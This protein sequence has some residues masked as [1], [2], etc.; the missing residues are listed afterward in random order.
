MGVFVLFAI[1]L[2]RADALLRPVP[3]V[4]FSVRLSALPV[5]PV[6]PVLPELH[7]C[8]I[9]WLYGLPGLSFLKS[10]LAH[11][12]KKTWLP[13]PLLSLPYLPKLSRAS[14]T[15]LPSFGW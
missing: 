9:A 3:S 11:L 15:Y 1:L 7:D 13:R 4:L 5:L 6:L 10:S 2:L 12:I 8:M 14:L